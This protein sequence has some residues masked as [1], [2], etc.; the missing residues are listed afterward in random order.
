MFPCFCRFPMYYTSII[1]FGEITAAL[2]FL[3]TVLMRILF[4]GAHF[5]S[6]YTEYHIEASQNH[7]FII[8]YPA[9]V[10]VSDT[11]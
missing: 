10:C 2:I 4:K 7:E 1:F 9:F 11:S 5:P 8:V 6:E 3:I